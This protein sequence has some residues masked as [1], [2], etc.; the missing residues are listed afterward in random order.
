MTDRTIKTIKAFKCLLKEHKKTDRRFITCTTQTIQITD[1]SGT[2]GGMYFRTYMDE[3]PTKKIFGIPYKWKWVESDREIV[4]FINHDFISNKEVI[5]NPEIVEKLRKFIHQ[6]YL[7]HQDY[8]LNE[9]QKKEDHID[10]MLDQ[11][12]TCE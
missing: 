12:S 5:D 4:V 8:L 10:A 2:Y 7:E 1:I 9:E 6:E 11:L 3:V